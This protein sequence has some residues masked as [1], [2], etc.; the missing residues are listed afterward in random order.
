M[1]S[2]K[3]RCHDGKSDAPAKI[4]KLDPILKRSLVDDL[5]TE[6][7]LLMC[8]NFLVERD[9]VAHENLLM[10]MGKVTKDDIEKDKLVHAIQIT[11]SNSGFHNSK[12]TRGYITSVSFYHLSMT[13]ILTCEDVIEIRSKV[14]DLEK[15]IFT[16]YEKRF[17]LS[18]QI[19]DLNT[20]QSWGSKKEAIEITPLEYPSLV[21]DKAFI[22]GSRIKI[23]RS[24]YSITDS[25]RA[26]WK[27]G[28]G[29]SFKVVCKAVGT[30]KDGFTTYSL[31]YSDGD[32]C[33]N[34]PETQVMMYTGGV[35]KPSKSTREECTYIATIL[36]VLKV[37]NEVR[38]LKVTAHPD[39]NLKVDYISVNSLRLLGHRVENNIATTNDKIPKET[40]TNK[41]PENG[42]YYMTPQNLNNDDSDDDD[43]DN[44]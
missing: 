29:S 6:F 21:I 30:D 35:A 44:Y 28:N 7:S 27:D 11:L 17:V 32:K 19:E 3:K 5:T 15:K 9:L 8:E 12:Y 43:S 24:L 20:L 38:S 40:Y 10:L 26:Y 14:K 42:Y 18:K 16:N 37:N 31:N 41:S 23:M 2:S 1:S 33:F 13:Q 22:V 25:L 34:V 36:E 39:I 4:A